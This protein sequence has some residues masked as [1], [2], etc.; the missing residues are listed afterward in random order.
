MQYQKL[1]NFNQA[2]LETQSISQ[3]IEISY[4]WSHLLNVIGLAVAKKQQFKLINN[5]TQHF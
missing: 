5:N 2:T 3:K 4:H 1:L